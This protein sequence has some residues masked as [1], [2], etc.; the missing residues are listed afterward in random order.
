MEVRFL[1][2]LEYSQWG[3]CPVLPT[4]LSSFTP[5]LLLLCQNRR[6]S[7]LK[8]SRQLKEAPADNA[9]GFLHYN[10]NNMRQLIS[11]LRLR[12]FPT[13]QLFFPTMNSFKKSRGTW[14]C[15]GCSWSLTKIMENPGKNAS[16]S[17][18]SDSRQGRS[19]LGDSPGRT[20]MDER[21][22]LTPSLSYDSSEKVTSSELQNVC[23]SPPPWAN[24]LSQT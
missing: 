12:G 18:V 19:V 1:E 22:C 2:Q 14:S 7:S 13:P 11:S 15:P 23:S 10:R 17:H 20:C 4:V 8:A 9:V 21:R 16:L 3:A 5:Q 6:I 24:A